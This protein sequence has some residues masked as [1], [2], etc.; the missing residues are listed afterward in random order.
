MIFCVQSVMRL[1]VGAGLVCKKLSI[2]YTEQKA[3]D[4]VYFR[5]RKALLL[6]KIVAINDRVGSAGR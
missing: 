6:A 2:G 4:G 5:G 1:L 3:W